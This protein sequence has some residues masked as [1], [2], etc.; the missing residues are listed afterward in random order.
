MEKISRYHTWSIYL[1][2]NVLKISLCSICYFIVYVICEIECEMQVFNTLN[3]FMD[4]KWFSLF[5]SCNCIF[6]PSVMNKLSFIRHGR[7]K[8]N[9]SVQKYHL[10]TNYIRHIYFFIWT[11]KRFSQNILFWSISSIHIKKF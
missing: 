10:I 8:N 11:K 4:N 1:L 5:N 9:F 7:I 2:N 6:S 3:S